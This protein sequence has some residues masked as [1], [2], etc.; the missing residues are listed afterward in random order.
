MSNPWSNSPGSSVENN[1]SPFYNGNKTKPQDMVAPLKQCQNVPEGMILNEDD[2]ILIGT[3]ELDKLLRGK[4]QTYLN[5]LKYSRDNKI[6]LYGDGAEIA[7]DLFVKEMLTDDCVGS[8]VIDK[9]V[10]VLEVGNDYGLR[11]KIVDMQTIKGDHNYYK[12]FNNN[13]TQFNAKLIRDIVLVYE[14]GMVVCFLNLHETFTEPLETLEP[15]YIEAIQSCSVADYSVPL[16]VVIEAVGLSD[17]LYDFADV[18]VCVDYRG[19][20]DGRLFFDCDKP[21]ERLFEPFYL[22]QDGVFVYA[23]D[24]FNPEVMDVLGKRIVHPEA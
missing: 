5:I 21:G 22:Y 23:D 10:N 6:I 20:E 19:A 18:A 17:S 9:G 11:S 15:Q 3:P 12:L 1:K 24:A 14:I 8:T 13:T 7:G 16:F 2:S 4:R